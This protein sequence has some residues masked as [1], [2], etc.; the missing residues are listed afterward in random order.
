MAAATSSQ[1]PQRSTRLQSSWSHK[2]WTLSRWWWLRCTLP[3]QKE[4]PCLRCS[5]QTSQ[6]QSNPG[7][8]LGCT[9]QETPPHPSSNS[10]K[11]L[12]VQSKVIIKVNKTTT[13]AHRSKMHLGLLVKNSPWRSHLS[14]RTIDLRQDR[15]LIESKS[16]L[17]MIKNKTLMHLIFKSHHSNQNSS[18]RLQI[19]HTLILQ[20]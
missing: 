18:Q 8:A 11:S 14:W 7:R 10:L 15:S 17:W 20:P 6:L 1:I 2:P 16:M 19:Y 9:L 4:R 12:S 3:L 13:W 5:P